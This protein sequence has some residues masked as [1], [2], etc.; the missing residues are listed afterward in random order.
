MLIAIIHSQQTPQGYY[1][2]KVEEDLLTITTA[3]APLEFLKFT[4]ASH[5]ESCVRSTGI[6]LGE[7]QWM[8]EFNP[9]IAKMFGL[10]EG[11]VS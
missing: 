7:R 9:E 10:P 6:P 3:V 1:E 8:V 11:F 4:I 2:L 5:L